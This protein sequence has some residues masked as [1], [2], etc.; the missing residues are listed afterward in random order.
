MRKLTLAITLTATALYSLSNFAIADEYNNSPDVQVNDGNYNNNINV[1]LSNDSISAGAS[2]MAA[3]NFNLYANGQFSS[4]NGT[5]GQL[6]GEFVKRS[7]KLSFGFGAKA[8]ALMAKHRKNGA[9]IALGGHAEYQLT[10]L[11]G[12]GAETYYSPNILSFHHIDRYLSFGG[13]ISYRVLQNVDII[14]GWRRT[15]FDYSAE[16]DLRYENNF[17]LESDYKF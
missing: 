9:V 4:D 15:S 8:I 12:I 1:Q 14:G 13:H 2:A 17:Y 7:G 5:I 11:I 16:D 3:P 6:G 10:D